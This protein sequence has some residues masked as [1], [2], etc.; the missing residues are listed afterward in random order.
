MIFEICSMTSAPDE[1]SSYCGTVA[2]AK[3]DEKIFDTTLVAK[4]A[5]A[6]A[7]RAVGQEGHMPLTI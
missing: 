4:K 2:D 3:I 7:A 6:P 1:K 5:F